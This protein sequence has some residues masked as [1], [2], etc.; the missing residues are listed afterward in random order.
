MAKND[1]TSGVFGLEEIERGIERWTPELERATTFLCELRRDSHSSDYCRDEDLLIGRG[2]PGAWIDS[3]LS[4]ERQFDVGGNADRQLGEC[5]RLEI[6]HHEDGD[7]ERIIATNFGTL[8]VSDTHLKMSPQERNSGMSDLA[9]RIAK[10]LADGIFSD[11]QPTLNDARIAA[12]VDVNRNKLRFLFKLFPF[13][14]GDA[15]LNKLLSLRG[16]VQVRGIDLHQRPLMRLSDVVDWQVADDSC[17]G[18]PELNSSSRPWL[19]LLIRKLEQNLRAKLLK[20]LMEIN[21]DFP[22][23]R[24][25]LDHLDVSVAIDSINMPHVSLVLRIDWPNDAQF[26]ELRSLNVPVTVSY[27]PS[28][29]DPL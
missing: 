21:H 4:V 8:V 11:L 28:D 17:F 14:L 15:F 3:I 10:E 19:E 13:L 16:F 18:W 6:I 2:A 23:R 25:H 27:S 1:R 20:S 22:I 7:L 12:R 9:E 5:A 26:G 24:E 29:Q